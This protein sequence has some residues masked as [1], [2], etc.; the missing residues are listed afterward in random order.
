MQKKRIGWRPKIFRMPPSAIYTPGHSASVTA[1]MARRTAQTHAAFI[2]PQLR[3]AWRIL[4]LGC[5]PGTIT[6]GLAERVPQ[7]SVLGMDFNPQQIANA[8]TRAR[9]RGLTNTDFIVGSL[10]TPDFPDE[11]FDL[12]FAHAVFAHLADPIAALRRLRRCVRPGGLIAL[13][14]PEWGGL[15]VHPGG[16]EMDRALAAYEALPRGN[17]GQP[18]RG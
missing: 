2:L 1:F 6:I 16:A 18:R 12:V 10:E 11:T 14:S 3:S 5:G 15:V 8:Q 7:G 9:Q 17:G 4:D 13:R